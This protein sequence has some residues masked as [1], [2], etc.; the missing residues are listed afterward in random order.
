MAEVSKPRS[1]ATGQPVV[2]PAPPPA[3]LC[4]GV[5][6]HREDNPAFTA[7]R[8]GILDA[9]EQALDLI[10]AAVVSARANLEV[11]A[12]RLH[13]LLADG[14]DELTAEG[15]LRRGWE[16]VAPLPFGLPLNVAIN[17]HPAT[18]EDAHALLRGPGSLDNV[19]SQEV[20]ARAA[21][22]FELGA[23]ARRFEL[24][25]RDA[26]IARLYLEKLAY[27]EDARSEA[28]F[29]AESS[30]RVAL[31]G[32]VMI[33]QS[34]LL[35]AVWDGSTRALVGGTGHTIQVALESGA[36]VL[37]INA[38]APEQWRILRG[39]ESLVGP[40]SEQ[41]TADER[42]AAIDQLVA[43]ALSPPAP[44]SKKRRV[45]PSG[46]EALAHETWPERS[47]WPF[48]AYRR[49][50]ALFGSDSLRGR[51][52]NLIQT[53]ETPDAIAGGSASP[54]LAHARRLPGQDPSTIERIEAAILRR[55]AW[56]DGV[57]A[58]LSDVY[59]GGMTASF[60]FAFLA[61]IGGIA[62]LPFSDTHH[63]WLF[64]SFEL[65]LLIGILAFTMIGS[66]RRW[67]TRWFETRRVA[68]YLR[69]GPILSLLGV[70][71]AAGRWPQGTETSWPER[72]ARN[73]LRE[74][75]LPQLVV[76]QSFLRQAARDLLLQH[77][78]G[79]R[80]YHVAK[81][82]RL[83]A[84]HHNLDNAAQILFA[85][86]IISVATYLFCKA[87]NTIGLWPARITDWT[88]IF[89]T[90]LGVLLP[91]LGGAL[92]GVRYFGDFERFAAISRVTAEKLQGIE[93][94]IEQL[95]RAP[96]EAMDYGGVSDLAHATDDVVVT[97]IESW[98][99][100]FA[101]KHVTVPV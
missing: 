28:T 27:R 88:S 40:G 82:R 52:R 87:G 51:F 98:Q 47:R 10:D 6:G 29:A 12:T 96:E 97:E 63:K 94:R 74:V 9:I 19:Q 25:D 84:V 66:R 71:R 70:A 35:V 62:Y 59:R 3:R 77:V 95:L 2:A 1:V 5:T 65:L 58:W 31:A 14:T 86:A 48:H 46:H 13:S 23:R 68:E 50:E 73:A 18:A 8:A 55:F 43:R 4:V 49:V 85:L 37:W 34:D 93:T 11:A 41:L 30:L 39:P 42:A 54:M 67:H 26:L 83:A 90:F 56:A 21:R 100:V 64:A 101:G 91:T 33:E 78:R 45:R 24:A 81:A 60:L 99:A 7:N 69:H 38:H 22:L 53:Y 44:A 17:A 92:A 61:I 80:E 76:T 57:S 75:G 79:Q 16:F 32:R 36:P 89:F 20:R 15:A 72:C